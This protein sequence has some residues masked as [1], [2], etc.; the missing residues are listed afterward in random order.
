MTDDTAKLNTS[1]LGTKKYWDDFYNLEH[2]NFQSNPIDTGECWFE[3]SNA[4]DKICEF[5]FSQLSSIDNI[6]TCDLGTGNGHLL[7]QLYDEGLRGELVGVDYSEKSIEFAKNIAKDGNY[8]VNFEQCDLLKSN[9]KFVCENE[10]K[11]DRS[12]LRKKVK[13]CFFLKLALLLLII[14]TT[15]TMKAVV[16]V[17]Q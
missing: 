10:E 12:Y 3:D 14:I 4:E 15:H 16:S 1:I 9:D 13:C 7:F 2:S 17:S 6:K 11:F 8:K 5:V